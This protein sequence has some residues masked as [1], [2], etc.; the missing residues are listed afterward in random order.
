[1]CPRINKL[2]FLSACRIFCPL[3]E[4]DSK[5]SNLARTAG[6]CGRDFFDFLDLRSDMMFEP[7]LV[8]EDPSY[9]H[10]H[11][12]LMGTSTMPVSMP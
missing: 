12:K 7:C 6:H 11:S 1:M 10:L 2:S 4:M 8:D 5:K 9:A 3:K